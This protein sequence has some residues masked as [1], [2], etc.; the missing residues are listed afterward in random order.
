MIICMMDFKIRYAYFY[1]H[2]G[3]RRFDLP[4]IVESKMPVDYLLQQDYRMTI[5]T[6]RT[7]AAA[8]QQH[9]DLR[10]SRFSASPRL[11]SVTPED[12]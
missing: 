12:L 8:Q 11:V 5:C 6:R 2:F 9:A 7:L 10:L 4:R 1:Q 3:M